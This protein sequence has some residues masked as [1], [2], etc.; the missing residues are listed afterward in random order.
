ML[1]HE[2]VVPTEAGKPTTPPAPSERSAVREGTSART[3][4]V[5]LAAA[6]ALT[7]V[8][9]WAY[10][11]RVLGTPDSVSYL[12]AARSLADD[13]RL[14][15][16]T[17]EPFT[18]YAPFYSVLI[19]A[20][21]KLGFTAI[22]AARVVNAVALGAAVFVAGS[23]IRSVGRSSEVAVAGGALAVL[24]PV[25][26]WSKAIMTETLFVALVMTG[27]WLLS[28]AVLRDRSRLGAA[29]GVFVGLSICTRYSGMFLLALTAVPLLVTSRPLRRRIEGAVSFLAPA[30]LIGLV[31]I[32]RNV[33]IDPAEPL[34]LRVS[35]EVGPIAAVT[36]MAV[37]IGRWA[38][39]AV[40]PW[41]VGLAGIVGSVLLVGG[42]VRSAWSRVSVGRRAA[43]LVPIV[44]AAMYVVGMLYSAVT[45]NINS[46]RSRMLAPAGVLW[47]VVVVGLG[48]YTIRTTRIGGWA[49]R[50]ST[51]IVAAPVGLLAVAAIGLLAVTGGGTTTI[52][53]IDDPLGPTLLESSTITAVANEPGVLF[54]NNP[55]SAALA[56]DRP[57]QFAP[58]SQ[59]WASDEPLPDPFGPLRRAA[60]RERVV[61]AWLTSYEAASPFMIPLDE[62]RRHCDTEEIESTVDGHVLLVRGCRG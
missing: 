61:L 8:L 55:W 5:A 25:G 38:T 45:T 22:D 51:A 4:I 53:A 37:G 29:G 15:D 36:D 32:L 39:P 56:L 7:A 19:A 50:R 16:V 10:G 20:V 34:G 47:L 17:G 48:W 54:S 13:V 30:L 18:Q 52:T 59:Y 46:L 60:R 41:W 26:F 42:A 49:R 58:M 14:T 3:I 31:P 28:L 24:L 43:V 27:C 11:S 6:G 57:V 23:W 21:M 1:R 62:V 9:A 33:S 12:V 2:D 35:G 40:L 44:G